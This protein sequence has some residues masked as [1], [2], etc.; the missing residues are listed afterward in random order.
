[1]KKVMFDTYR[2]HIF[3]KVRKKVNYSVTYD[4]TEIQKRWLVN[5]KNEILLEIVE[6]HHEAG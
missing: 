6:K 2:S 5:I 4:I 3:M 1:M